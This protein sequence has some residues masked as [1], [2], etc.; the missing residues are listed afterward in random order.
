LIKRPRYSGILN[1]NLQISALEVIHLP[2]ITV[3][4]LENIPHA[5]LLDFP[6]GG[7]MLLSQINQIKPRAQSFLDQYKWM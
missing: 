2:G 3:P 6:E 1:D 5:Q 4:T 7:H